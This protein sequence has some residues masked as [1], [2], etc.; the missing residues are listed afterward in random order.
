MK[1]YPN[2]FAYSLTLILGNSEQFYYTIYGTSKADVFRQ[3]KER[4]GVSPTFRLRR[5]AKDMP[6][7][8]KGYVRYRR[9]KPDWMTLKQRPSTFLIAFR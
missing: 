7:Y 6:G 9:P 8:P 3:I 1:K 4:L 5:I 2:H